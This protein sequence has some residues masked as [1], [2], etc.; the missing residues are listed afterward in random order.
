MVLLIYEH[1]YKKIVIGSILLTR[2]AVSLFQ[3]SEIITLK[4]DGTSYLYKRTQ[5]LLFSY[6]SH[7]TQGITKEEKI[8]SYSYY[9]AK[10]NIYMLKYLKMLFIRCQLILYVFKTLI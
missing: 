5:L 4:A 10:P 1:L 2:N 6:S 7:S 9:Q 3:V 8:I